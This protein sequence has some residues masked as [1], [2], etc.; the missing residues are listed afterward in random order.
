MM[1]F[2]E[3]LEQNDP[4]LYSEI[5]WRGLKNRGKDMAQGAWDKAG[6]A[7][8][9]KARNILGTGALMAGSLMGGAHLNSPSGPI[10]GAN[11][12]RIQQNVKAT[13]ADLA[14]IKQ[15]LARQKKATQS[16]QIPS[17]EE[18]QQASD[19]WAQQAKGYGSNNPDYKQM[20]KN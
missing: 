15:N 2:D 9:P 5:D 16:I 19:A 4:E 17:P 6:D 8:G 20:R 1:T 7:V 14:A 18:R 10:H 3:W 13:K 11:L 12:D